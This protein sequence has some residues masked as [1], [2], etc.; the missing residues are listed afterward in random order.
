MKSGLLNRLT[1]FSGGLPHVNLLKFGQLVFVDSDLPSADLNVVFGVPDSPDDVDRIT[2]HCLPRNLP[3]TWWLPTDVASPAA[4]WLAAH[5]WFMEDVLIGMSLSQ[6]NNKLFDCHP[7]E[8]EPGPEVEI[9]RCD[10]LERVR[11]M[12]LIARSLYSNE[13]IR[14]GSLIES[15]I[16]QAADLFL[17]QGDGLQSWVAYVGGAAVA[18]ISAHSFGGTLDIFGQATKPEYRCHGLD[19]MMVRHVL[20]WVDSQVAHLQATAK[21]VKLYMQMGFTPVNQFV[22]WSNKHIL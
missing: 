21:G 20:T 19:Q 22:L 6:E 8:S 3:A 17:T 11:D 9:K 10:T 4:W 16:E 1:L 15:S 5:G 12:A 2:R 7:K 14:E 18:T 13:K